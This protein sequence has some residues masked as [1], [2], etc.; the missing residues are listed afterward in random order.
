MARI[1]AVTREALSLHQQSVLDMILQRRGRIGEAFRVIL[2][3]LEV[4]RPI[5]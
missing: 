4:A 2:H 3:S 1:P 5:A